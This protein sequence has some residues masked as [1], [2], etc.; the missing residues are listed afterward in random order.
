M[1]GHL[2]LNPRTHSRTF[3]VGYISGAAVSVVLVLIMAL[4]L[5]P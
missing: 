3:I 2:V 4:L 5:M 1:S